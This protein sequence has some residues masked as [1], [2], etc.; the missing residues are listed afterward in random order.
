MPPRISLALA[1]HNHQPVGNFDGVFEQAYQDSYLPFLDCF[2]SYPSLRISL[3]TSGS[4][5]EWLDEHHPEYVDRLAGLV[6]TG[7]IEIVGGAFYE[8]I[9]TM[10]PSRD[11]IGQI[12][13][14]TAWL[15]DRLGANVRG[16]WMPERV[17]EQSL[18]TDLVVGSVPPEKAGAASGLSTTASDLGISL[19]VAIVGSIAIATYRNEINGSLPPGLPA[20]AHAA[21]ADTLDGAVAA[22]AQLPA[23]SSAAVLEA[24]RAAFTSGL[25]IGAATAAAIAAVASVLAAT[26]LRHVRPTG[27]TTAPVVAPEQALED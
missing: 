21:A 23:E 25:N 4:L 5:M 13:R 11:R 17:W 16:I 7:R 18:T 2:E 3:H 8:P 19:G 10:I 22:A 15:E 9:L 27:Y 24:A 14:Y 20:D 12:R 1:I 26:R 6:A